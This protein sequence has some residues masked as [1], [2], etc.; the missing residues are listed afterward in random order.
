VTWRTVVGR[1]VPE[2]LGACDIRRRTGRSR[3]CSCSGCPAARER[4]SGWSGADRGSAAVHERQPFRCR[5]RARH[6]SGGTAFAL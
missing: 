1:T 5:V 2:L 6:G 3:L 4:P